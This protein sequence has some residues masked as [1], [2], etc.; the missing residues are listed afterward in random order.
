M[1][2]ILHLTITF[3]KQT[4]QTIWH[5]H[6]ATINF[7]YLVIDTIS[8]MWTNKIMCIVATKIKSKCLI[9]EVASCIGLIIKIVI[10][11][12]TRYFY[13]NNFI[14]NFL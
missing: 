8:V 2:A 7:Y 9:G 14:N 11:L 12:Q 13:V 1:P 5:Y 4:C 10:F 6:I 3:Y